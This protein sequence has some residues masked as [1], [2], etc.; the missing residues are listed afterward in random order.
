MRA[1]RRPL[2]ALPGSGSGGRRA[3]RRSSASARDTAAV[4]GV[5]FAV[6]DD[7]LD[8]LKSWRSGEARRRGVPAYVVF[9]DTTL[10]ALAAGR[11]GDMSALRAV[12][13]I[14]PAKLE[15]YGDVLLKLVAGK[16]A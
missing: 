7:L 5:A 12:K 10:A 2:L 4:P 15:A 11:P 16:E 6:D 13:G 14:G 1:E 3:Q 9:H 8:R